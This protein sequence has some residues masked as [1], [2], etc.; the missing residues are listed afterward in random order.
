MKIVFVGSGERG[1]S[2]ARAERLVLHLSRL[3]LL[4]AT[5]EQYERYSREV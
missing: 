5:A 2:A 1:R 4:T 3:R